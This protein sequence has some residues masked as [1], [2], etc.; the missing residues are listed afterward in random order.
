MS[1][2]VSVF[3][4]KPAMRARPLR[5]AMYLSG[6]FVAKAATSAGAGAELIHSVRRSIKGLRSYTLRAARSS[7]PE[8]LGLWFWG[9]CDIALFTLLPSFAAGSA[10]LGCSLARFF[11]VG[12]CYLCC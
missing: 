4:V 9:L 11:L 3:S 10:L 12:I 1:I 8:Y 6:A 2:R 7:S 5:L